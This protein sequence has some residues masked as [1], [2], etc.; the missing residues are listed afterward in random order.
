MYLVQDKLSNLLLKKKSP[1]LC[2]LLWDLK[3]RCSGC[4]LW[5]AVMSF[6]GTDIFLPARTA[7]RFFCKYFDEQSSHLF[8]TFER[9]KCSIS[10]SV[11]LLTWML[12]VKAMGNHFHGTC[13]A[14]HLFHSQAWSV[15][16]ARSTKLFRQNSLGVTFT[17]ENAT[18]QAD[19][20]LWRVNFNPTSSF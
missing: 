7:G 16:G 15:L 2:Y 19:F 11:S 5:C 17:R 9:G 20:H 3:E 12:S 18:F 4:C 10:V 1:F 8:L 14:A 6:V 13:N